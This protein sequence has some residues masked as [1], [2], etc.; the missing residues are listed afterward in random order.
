MRFQNRELTLFVLPS[1]FSKVSVVV[2]FHLKIEDLA[3]SSFGVFD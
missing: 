2:S 1:N 3:F